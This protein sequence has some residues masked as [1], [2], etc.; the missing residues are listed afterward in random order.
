MKFFLYTHFFALLSCLY[1]GNLWAQ[2]KVGDPNVRVNTRLINQNKT[3]YPQ[4]ER[5]SKAGVEGGIP[6]PNSSGFQKFETIEPGNSN[7]INE[8]ISQMSKALKK[9]EKGLITLKNGKY[10]IDNT[11]NMNSNVSLQGETRD[12]VECIISVTRRSTFHFSNIKNA[13]IYNLTMNS[14]LGAPK[15][16]WN[17]S[18]NQNDEVKRNE[19]ISV[20]MRGTTENCWLDKVTILNAIRDP[21]RCSGTHNT[22]RDLIVDGAH[23]KAGGAQGYFFIQN[24][25]NLITGCSITHL[26]HISLQGEHVEFNVVYD[27]DF[28]QEISFHSGDNGNNLIENNRITLP[29]DMPPVAPDDTD[30]TPFREARNNKPVYFAIMGPWSTEHTNSAKPNWVYKNECVQFNHDFGARRPWSNPNIVYKGPKKIAIGIQA[31]IDN[32]PN[33]NLNPPVG[34]TLYPIILG[35]PNPTTPPEPS[36]NIGATCDD[37][38]DCTVNDKFEKNC[39]CVGEIPEVVTASESLSPIEDAF[40][41][42]GKGINSDRIRVEKNE[43]IT[44]LKFDLSKH[45]EINSDFALSLTALDKPGNGTIRV[46]SAKNNWNENSLSRS[47]APDKIRELGSINGLYVNGR[48]YTINL[49]SL[50]IASGTKFI[51]LVL[52]QTNGSNVSFASSV[53][54]NRG[55]KLKFTTTTDM[56]CSDTLNLTNASFDIDTKSKL[57]I[58]PNPTSGDITVLLPFSNVYEKATIHIIN[59]AGV[60]VQETILSSFDLEI[61]LNLEPLSKG[62]YFLNYISGKKSITRKIIKQ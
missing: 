43:R 58:Y 35:D 7:S 18:L 61:G 5:W 22:F 28:R 9:G 24:S 54:K 20:L 21:L 49:P 10:T 15:Y 41:Q 17:Y 27:N 45:K 30:S 48:T 31:R 4:M 50:K 38:D 2:I 47:N 57:K 14:I 12:G 59:M 40:L 8:A 44:Y 23:K 46:F 37:G 62:V 39:N 60:V 32:F 56:P 16:K 52:E 55:P 11:I 25:D 34:G 51:S 19:N 53:D 26:R 3:N 6:F 1:S 13:G 36:C 33:S 42:N 29:S